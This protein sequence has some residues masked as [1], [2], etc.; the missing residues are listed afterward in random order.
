MIEIRIHGRGGQGV[1]TAAELL[2]KAAFN[3][4]K[5]CLAFPKFGPDRTGAPVEAYCRI[6]DR[7]IKLR[8]QIYEP[9]C[10]I[11]LDQGL[12]KN[13]DITN[14]MKKNGV[15]IINAN[16]SVKMKFR[17]CSIDA[18]QV[19]LDVIGKPIVNT[20]MLGAFAKATGVIT[21]KSLEKAIYGRFS[22]KIADSNI[23]AVRKAYEV[24]KC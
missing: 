5:Y 2:A 14:G 19:A 24:L 15:I 22:G 7:P 3:N 11:V 4:G 13:I 10:L 16:G 23:A 6:D 12:A 8:T 9:D 20:V 18:T 1:V 21:L 17:A